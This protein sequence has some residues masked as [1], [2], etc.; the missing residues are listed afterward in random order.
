MVD[1]FTFGVNSPNFVEDNDY[2][3]I[4]PP[5][6][7]DVL[8]VDD[9]QWHIDGA[10]G[11]QTYGTY[12]RIPDIYGTGPFKLSSTEKLR[13]IRVDRRWEVW[14]VRY[15]TMIADVPENV[16]V[17][18][19]G[20]GVNYDGQDYTLYELDDPR[21]FAHLVYQVRLSEDGQDG[22][23]D[24]MLEPWIDLRADR[25]DHRSR[26]PSTCPANVP[27]PPSAA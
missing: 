21:P 27:T 26:C 3:R 12:W 25:C 9:I 1:L 6:F 14:A 24:I 11:V 8:S 18:A 20:E 4:Q 17:T 2:N 22:A 13:Q 5:D 19:V 23:R 10:A 15:A 7:M 16:P